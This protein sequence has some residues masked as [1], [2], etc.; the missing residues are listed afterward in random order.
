MHF[1]FRVLFLSFIAC[2]ILTHALSDDSVTWSRK[3]SKM[4]SWWEL[5]TACDSERQRVHNH[6][7]EQI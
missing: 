2:V 5:Y 6:S 7:C 4:F 3:G 1:D